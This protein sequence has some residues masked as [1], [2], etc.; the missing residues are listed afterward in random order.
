MQG[1][2]IVVTG[3]CG[4]GPTDVAA[5][6]RKLEAGK[7]G[8]N[9]SHQVPHNNVRRTV[10]GNVNRPPT[11]DELRRMEDVV[12]LAM[13]DGAWGLSTGLIYNPGIYAK[14]DEII[15]LAK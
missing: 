4:A 8:T 7:I 1:F 12:D 15:A 10:M 14:T 3:N 5:Y 11:A 9:I 2:T 13:K 6:F